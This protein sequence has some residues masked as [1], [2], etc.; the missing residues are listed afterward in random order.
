MLNLNILD[1]HTDTAEKLQVFTGQIHPGRKWSKLTYL[2][3]FHVVSFSGSIPI[4][5][6]QKNGRKRVK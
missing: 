1:T 3:G 2:L 5:D 6:S 4:Y